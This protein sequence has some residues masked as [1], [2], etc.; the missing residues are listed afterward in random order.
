ML[1]R[2]VDELPAGGV[3]HTMIVTAV[4]GFFMALGLLLRGTAELVK[5]AVR[6]GTQS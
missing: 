1:L 6:A 2:T 4:Y 5:K 3:S